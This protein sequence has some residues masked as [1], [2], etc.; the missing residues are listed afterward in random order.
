MTTQ[1]RVLNLSKSQKDSIEIL[2]D[3]L[4][5]SFEHYQPKHLE[6]EIDGMP[7]IAMDILEVIRFLALDTG[8]YT[9]LNKF[10][11]KR[12]RSIAFQCKRI[13]KQ[14]NHVKKQ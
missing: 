11:K 9:H 3:D 12:I 10:Q 1:S 7:Q 8:N 14:N 6:I 4:R 5:N 13:L 2:H